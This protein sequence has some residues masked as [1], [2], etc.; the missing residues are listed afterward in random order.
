MKT[1]SIYIDIPPW[2]DNLK[3]DDFIVCVGQRKTNSV[4]HIVRVKSIK[5]Q[6]SRMIRNYLE[7]INTDLLTAL[8]RDESQSLKPMTWY[9]R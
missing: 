1:K 8:R 6:K 9:K 2:E 3:A 5:P 4:Y 7:V